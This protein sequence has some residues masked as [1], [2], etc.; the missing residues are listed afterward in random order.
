MFIRHLI[1]NMYS[2]TIRLDGAGNAQVKLPDYFESANKDPR[3]QLTAIGTPTVPYTAKEIQNGIFSIKGEPNT[4]VSWV[5]YAERN[6]PTIQYYRAKLNLDQNVKEK[7]G[8]ERGKYLT[9]AAFGKDEKLSQFYN[10]P[11]EPVKTQPTTSVNKLNN[12]KPSPK[13]KE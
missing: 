1:M 7:K 10:K 11:A 8:A 12:P 6:D 4:K 2:G 13:I 5:V 3:Y 9:P